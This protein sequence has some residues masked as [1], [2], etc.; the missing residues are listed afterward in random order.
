M[1][2]RALYGDVMEKVRSLTKL[3]RNSLSY[4]VSIG[5][6]QDIYRFPVTLAE[7]VDPIVVGIQAFYGS[8]KIKVEVGY[9]WQTGLFTGLRTHPRLLTLSEALSENL[10]QNIASW[11]SRIISL[12]FIRV[13]VYKSDE[14]ELDECDCNLCEE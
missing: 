14:D 1:S 3:Y 8:N 13:L 2:S 7:Q 9:F 10:F 5:Q 12:A 11:D 6:T 4:A